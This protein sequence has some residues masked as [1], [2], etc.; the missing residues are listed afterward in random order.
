MFL[1]FEIP[2]I[3]SLDELTQPLCNQTA[4]LAD[5]LANVVGIVIILLLAIVFKPRPKSTQPLTPE[6]ELE[7]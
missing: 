1:S 2:A 4:S 3:A 7:S 5:W 6:P